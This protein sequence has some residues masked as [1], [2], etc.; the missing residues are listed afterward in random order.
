MKKI[1]IAIT[2]MFLTILTVT[3]QEN[4]DKF[5]D[6]VLYGGGFNVGFGSDFTTIAISPSAIYNFSDVFSSGVSLSYLY[7]KN[8]F[9][10]TKANVYGGSLITLFN[11]AQA[12]QLSAEFEELKINVKDNIGNSDSYWNPAL[13]LGAAYNMGNV[14]IGLR[15]DALYDDDKSIY[16][17]A[18]TPVF[19]FYF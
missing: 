8:K 16:S 10:N 13:Y 4:N 14:S 3:A 2:F 15:Y 1:A 9:L 19:R 11:V 17:S 6:N 5:W 18:F 7:S 12:V